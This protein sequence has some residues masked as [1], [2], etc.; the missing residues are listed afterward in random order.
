VR[1]VAQAAPS[2]LLLK[3]SAKPSMQQRRLLSQVQ[4]LPLATS[5]RPKLSANL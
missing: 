1:A 4:F 2:K 5:E 3:S